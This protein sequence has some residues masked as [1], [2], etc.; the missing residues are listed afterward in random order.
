M[1]YNY[2]LENAIYYPEYN[3]IISITF[4]GVYNENNELKRYINKIVNDEESIVIDGFFNVLNEISSDGMKSQP[5][6]FPILSGYNIIN[7]DIPLLFKRYLKNI[8][9]INN[10]NNKLPLILKRALTIKPWESG[11]IDIINLWN[12]NGKYEITPLSTIINFLNLKRKLEL[13]TPFE[14][15]KYYW[16]NI[17]NDKEKTLEYISLQSANQTNIII[18][19]INKLRII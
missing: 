9:N 5:K 8:N 16:D 15:S 6:Y 4:G 10:I 14:L 11:V 3:K 12:F 7:Y 1:I 13:L 2:Y 17:K 19:I 18:Q